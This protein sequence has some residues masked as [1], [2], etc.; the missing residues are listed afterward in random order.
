MKK[1]QTQITLHNDEFNVDVTCYLF[2][3]GR[4][5]IVDANS[6]VAAIGYCNGQKYPSFSPFNSFLR[7]NYIHD[8]F[9]SGDKIKLDTIYKILNKCRSNSK[10]Y[11][12]T[13]WLIDELTKPVIPPLPC[14]CPFATQNN[15]HDEI[16]EI[17][18]EINTLVAKLQ[19]MLA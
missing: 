2:A 11:K 17:V 9:S 10:R 8:R 13:T 3:D 16:N 15:T 5:P 18:G 19:K 6:Y 4:Q 14:S 12:V 7:M 1:E